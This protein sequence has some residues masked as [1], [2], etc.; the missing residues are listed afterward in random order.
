MNWV[1]SLKTKERH[2]FRFIIHGHTPGIV[3]ILELPE[4]YKG[5]LMLK[6]SNKLEKYKETI[7]P[8]QHS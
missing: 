7:R 8:T 2:S 1:S 6:V 3:G 4:Q 5:E